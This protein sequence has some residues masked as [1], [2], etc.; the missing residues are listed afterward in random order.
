M[1]IIL[2][3]NMKIVSCE[4]SVG[5]INIYATVLRQKAERMQEE[6]N[7]EYSIP[8]SRCESALNLGGRQLALYKTMAY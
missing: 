3:N 2:G 1:G 6:K 4:R 7:L 8:L 5:V